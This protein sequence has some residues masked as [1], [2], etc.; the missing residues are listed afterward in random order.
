MMSHLV[1]GGLVDLSQHEH[2]G[3]GGALPVDA[4]E[5][6]AGLM[7]PH[8]AEVVGT[9]DQSAPQPTE[10]AQAVSAEEDAIAEHDDARKHGEGQLPAHRPTPPGDAEGIR[11][12]H[13]RGGQHEGAATG[14]RQGTADGEGA[15]RNNRAQVERQVLT[16]CRRKIGGQRQGRRGEEGMVLKADR[17][18]KGIAGHG[19]VRL[20]HDVHVQTRPRDER[21]RP[22]DQHQHGEGRGAHVELVCPHEPPQEVGG[23]RHQHH[24]VSTPCQHCSI[25]PVIPKAPASAPA[26]PGSPRRTSDRATWHPATGS[27]GGP[28]R[29]TP[30]P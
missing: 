3:L 12:S 15:S 14:R 2:A 5:R 21:H 26:E 11:E 25:T 22:G 28:A 30:D 24:A 20:H 29:G 10:P 19:V 6:L 18:L 7:R 27:R 17:E 1:P 9:V 8:T 16:G 23:H 4:A 13:P